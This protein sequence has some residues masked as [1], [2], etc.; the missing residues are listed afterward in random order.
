[1]DE[2]ARALSGGARARDDVPV[3]LVARRDED[4]DAGHVG[5]LR[6]FTVGSKTWE[7]V[8]T[9]VLP[10]WLP[11]GRRLAALDRGRITLVD[12]IAK[13]ASVVYAEPGRGFS[14]IARSPDARRLY[15]A[16][17]VNEADIWLMRFDE[18]NLTNTPEK[19]PQ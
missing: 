8:G 11:D 1:L 12:T 5:Q 15:F 9:G 6:V 4:R 3:G 13:T 18:A 7:S 2:A 10:R 17:S 19:R 14:S 16:S